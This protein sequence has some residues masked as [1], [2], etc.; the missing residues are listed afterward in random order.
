MLTFESVE[1]RPEKENHEE[2]HAIASVAYRG[3]IVLSSG[4]FD[5]STGK[6][7]PIISLTW[8]N[9]DGDRTIQ[10]ITDS[11]ER[12]LTFTEAKASGVDLAK[13]WI[14]RRSDELS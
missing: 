6:W 14:D 11:F 4:A 5:E 1:K 13:A 8:T 10:F 3:C 9:P 2:W 7:I 12:F